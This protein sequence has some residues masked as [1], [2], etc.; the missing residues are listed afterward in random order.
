MS[1]P[2]PR[3]RRRARAGETGRSRTGRGR[4]QDRRASVGMTVER[5]RALFQAGRTG[6]AVA[7][8]ERTAEAGDGEANFALANWRLFGQYGP[9]DV[10]AAHHHLRKAGEK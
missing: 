9:R 6:E 10:A 3:C 7:L 8:M 1:R 2:R 5:A 4:G